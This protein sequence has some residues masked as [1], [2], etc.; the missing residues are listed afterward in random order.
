LPDSKDGV[1]RELLSNMTKRGLLM[2][3]KE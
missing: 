1:I 3:L 2:R